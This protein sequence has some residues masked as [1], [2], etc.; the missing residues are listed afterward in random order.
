MLLTVD[1]GTTNFKASL[2]DFDGNRLAFASRALS[3]SEKFETDPS[4]WLT[5]FDE[6]CKELLSIFS[7]F[8]DVK[9]IVIS[10]NGPTLVPVFNEYNEKNFQNYFSLCDSKARLWLDRSAAKYQEEVSAVMG[11]YVDASFFLPKILYIKHEQNELYQK[12]KFF[13]GCPEYLAFILTGKACNVFPS[14]G[15]DRWFWNESSLEKLNLDASKFPSFIKP[16]DLF[17]TLLPSAS[18]RFC[19][20]KEIPVISGGPDF[21]ASLLGS[22]VTGQ[23]ELCDRT[24]SSDGINLCT[25]EKINDNSLMSYG[26]PI[27]PFW[28]LSGYLNTTGKAVDWVCALLGVTKF[29]DFISLAKNCKSGSNGV[30]FLPYL[31][32]ER[33]LNGET[34]AL[35][36]GLTLGTGRQELAK[37]VLEGI[38]FAIKDILTVMERAVSKELLGSLKTPVYMRVTGG[39][40]GCSY[41]NQIK[42]DITGL[43]IIEGVHKEAELSGLAMIGSCY[44]GKFNS[45][46]EA[47]CA[48]YR[49]ERT[50]EPKLNNKSFYDEMFYKYLSMKKAFK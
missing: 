45:Y 20:A 49:I 41:L 35:L 50:Y 12:T 48:F 29:D 15:F 9:A 1:I 11:G 8:K 27:K 13:L 30:L 38:A 33:T 10:G 22:G 4:K 24:G 46:K 2:W 6:C 14:Q 42:A 44:L 37:S 18:K 23:G 36:S 32:G 19:L 26:H 7:G 16:G 47:S 43:E 31:A 21:Y 25:L 28:N 3:V 5:A 40:A 39:L 34:S 17:G